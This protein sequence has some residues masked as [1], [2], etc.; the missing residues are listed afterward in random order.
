[1]ADQWDPKYPR[2]RGVIWSK[3]YLLARAEIYRDGSLWRAAFAAIVE[4]DKA[5]TFETLK[6]IHS[7]TSDQRIW[8]LIL[9]EQFTA[10]F[11]PDDWKTWPA[12]AQTV[13]EAVPEGW[14][15]ISGNLEGIP[16]HWHG[17]EER[18]RLWAFKATTLLVAGLIEGQLPPVVAT[19]AESVRFVDGSLEGDRRPLLR[20]GD[21]VKLVKDVTRVLEN[22]L[23]RLDRLG[24]GP[25]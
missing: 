22:T 15:E 3:V 1:M 7:V 17:E 21:G 2:D 5:G 25:L 18:T 12:Y 6:Y 4:A 16:T 19:S 9:W 20:E 24:R 8:R 10:I 11:Q 23:Q 13:R 14:L